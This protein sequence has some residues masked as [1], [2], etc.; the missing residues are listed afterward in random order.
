MLAVY[1]SVY[2][3]YAIQ[4]TKVYSNTRQVNLSAQPVILCHIEKPGPSHTLEVP[5][6]LWQLAGRAWASAS[7]FVCMQFHAVVEA[8]TGALPVRSARTCKLIFQAYSSRFVQRPWAMAIV[9]RHRTLGV[10]QQYLHTLTHRAA[11]RVSS[12]P[13]GCY[14]QAALDAD[15][16]AHTCTSAGCSVALDGVH[17]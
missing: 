6:M 13:Q 3:T 14:M 16:L 15:M 11:V 8:R 4:G 17:E 1:C 2:T 12:Q 10:F 7:A 9:A 5:R